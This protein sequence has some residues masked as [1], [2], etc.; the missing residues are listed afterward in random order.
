LSTDC[1]VG[2]AERRKLI[3]LKF[4]KV[5][6]RDG[7][8]ESRTAVVGPAWVTSTQL[9]FVPF[10]VLRLL[11]RQ[12]RPEKSIVDTVLASLMIG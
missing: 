9:L 2:Y 4:G 11:R 6:M 8:L 5:R 10:T 7:D 1:L 12:A 3:K